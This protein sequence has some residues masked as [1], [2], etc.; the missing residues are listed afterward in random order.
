MPGTS[1]EQNDNKLLKNIQAVLHERTS[2]HEVR[3][4]PPGLRDRIAEFLRNRDR[5]VRH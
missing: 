3:T 4:E 2:P 1:S 5:R